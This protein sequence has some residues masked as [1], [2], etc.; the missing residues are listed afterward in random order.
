MLNNVIAPGKSIGGINLGENIKGVINRLE[1]SH[2]IEQTNPNTVVVDSG[3][4]TIFHDAETG[5]IVAISCN[6]NFMGDFM[7]KLWPGMCVT[8][9]QENSRHQIA[10]CGFVEVDEHRGIGLSLPAKF[11]DF[12]RITDFLTPDFVFDELWVYDH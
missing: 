7:N 10:W 5:V 11:D 4:V 8:D 1:D 6:K 12:E 3:T 9:V 2:L